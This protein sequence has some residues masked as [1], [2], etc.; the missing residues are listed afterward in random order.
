MKEQVGR[1]ARTSALSQTFPGQVTDT[2]GLSSASLTHPAL[3]GCPSAFSS[4]ASSESLPGRAFQIQ[5]KN[6]KF[7]LG[8]DGLRCFS[9]T[10][11]FHNT[12][13]GQYNSLMFRRN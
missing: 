5:G 1:G 12:S 10:F 4:C 11:L 6:C 8:K 9:L 7:V 3:D 13:V 2:L